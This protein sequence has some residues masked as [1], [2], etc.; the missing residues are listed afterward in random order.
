METAKLSRRVVLVT[1]PV[2]DSE[3]KRGFHTQIFKMRASIIADR[4]APVEREKLTI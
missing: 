4:N 3:I 1:V 2:E